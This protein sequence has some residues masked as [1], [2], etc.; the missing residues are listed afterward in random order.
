MLAGVLIVL[1][2]FAAYSPALDGGFVW[3]DD[4]YVTANQNLLDAEGLR[5]I[6]FELGAVPQYYPLVHTTFWLEYRLWGLDPLGYHVVNVL[7]HILAALLLGRVLTTLRVPGAWLAA[8]IFALHPVGVE[9]AAWITER[10]NVLSAVFYFAAAL[11]YF[12]LADPAD[13]PGGDAPAERALPPRAVDGASQGVSR[14]R[15]SRRQSAV[16]ESASNGAAVVETAV[17]VPARDRSW[18]WYGLS[19]ALF[20]AALLSKTVTCSLPAALLLVRWWKRG[21]IGRRDLVP[22]AP[23][24][25]VGLAFGLL[26]AWMEKH[27]VGAQ[28]AEWSLGWIESGLV[29]GR[30]L[31]FYAGKLLWPAQLSFIYPRWTIDATVWWQWIFP[32]AAVGAVAA[33][34]F[35]RHRIGRGPLVAVLFFAGTLAPALG[36]FNVYPMRYSYVADHFQYLASA[37]LIALAASLLARVRLPVAAA[38]PVVLGVLAW[39]QAHDYKDIETL[40]RATLARNP[41]CWLA[42]NNMGLLMRAQG[43]AGEAEYHY[44]AALRV[45]PDDGDINYNIGNLLAGTGR[46]GEAI[47]HYRLAIESGVGQADAHNNLGAA[48]LTRGDPRDLDEAIQHFRA[49]LELQP[50][51]PDTHYNLGNALVAK[52]DVAGAVSHY[53]EVLRIDPEH[54]RARAQLNALGIQ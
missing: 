6:W 27:H 51:R 23:F 10:K 33:L 49:A 43:R 8:A 21:A 3:D 20:V 16:R 39:N 22:L 45:Q 19:L 15:G 32:V 46:L 42:H 52:R 12:R 5:R 30:A 13:A 4:D 38:V 18:R 29:A 48:L 44:R 7:L 14:R 24:F 9:S 34:W 26:T 11:A 54:A 36:F 50:H 25:A 1:L 40:W 37:G 28:G 53:V 41:E 31:W 2:S 35:A 17:P 47:G